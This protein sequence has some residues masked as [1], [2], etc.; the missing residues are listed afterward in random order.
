M[1]VE[2]VAP[3]AEPVSSSD[4]WSKLFLWSARWGVFQALQAVG[5]VAATQLCH[6]S[7][8]GATDS[9]DMSERVCIPH[10]L[11]MMKFEFHII[12]TCTK[13]YSSFGVFSNHW[14]MEHKFLVYV[15]HK[16]RWQ[17]WPEGHGCPNGPCSAAWPMPH[18]PAPAPARNR[19]FHHVKCAV[20]TDLRGT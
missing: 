3:V 6:F 9:T 16:I 8:K 5:S 7:L 15:L 13:C 17:A 20:G 4:Y 14:K 19:V 12:L 1:H 11:W 10:Y 2:L 18:L